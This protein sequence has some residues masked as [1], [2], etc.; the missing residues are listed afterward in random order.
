[1]NMS[2]KSIIEKL[3]K[4]T[5]IHQQLIQ[6]SKGKTDLIKEG[7]VEKLQ[8]HLV[9]ERKLVQQLE[10]AENER[11]K[12]VDEW[13][14][15]NGHSLH[16]ATVT[17]MLEKIQVESEKEALEEHAVQLAEA[18]V[19]LK[20]QEQLN[21]ELIQQSMQFVQLSIDLL[22]PSLKNINYG[23]KPDQNPA[24]NRSVFDSKA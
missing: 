6:L 7:H 16:E 9:K 14:L 17:N 5:G 24:A 15:E 13:F 8:G 1:M 20:Q 10:K 11:K 19:Q 23:N 2:M 12:V 22:S 3:D 4:L 21:M 18:I